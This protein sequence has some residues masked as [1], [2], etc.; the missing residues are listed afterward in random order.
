MARREKACQGAYGQ[1]TEED[2]A[3]VGSEGPVGPGWVWPQAEGQLWP[4]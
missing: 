2:E 1:A 4:A 3:A